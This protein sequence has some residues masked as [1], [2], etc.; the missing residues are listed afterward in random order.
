[1]RAPV[2]WIILR[3]A[4]AA[5]ALPA[6][7]Q[8]PKLDF[9]FP[10]GGRAGSRFGLTVS[11]G[12]KEG[13]RLQASHPG[14][15]F[16]RPNAKEWEVSIAADTPAGLHWVFAS[17][18]QGA[19]TAK[20]F[21]VDLWNELSEVEPNDSVAQAQA[22]PKTAGL[23][24]GGLQRAGDVDHFA[25]ELAAGQELALSLDAYGLG[26]AVDALL[27]VI[28][29][30]GQRQHTASDSRNLDPA[31]RFKAKASGRHVIEV[32][33]FPHPPAADVRFTG[34]SSLVYRLK[35]AAG[36]AVWAA[37]PAAVALDGKTQVRWLGLGQD[38]KP[39]SLKASQILGHGR[40][41]RLIAADGLWPVEVLSS[42]KT[43]QM[44]REPNDDPAKAQ[45]MELGVMGALLDR[46]G[47]VDVFAL[48]LKKGDNLRASVFGKRLGLAADFSLSVEGPDGKALGSA[49]D[50]G[51]QNSD[52]VLQFTATADGVHR[53]RV[54]EVM[55]R[56]PVL[57]NAYALEVIKPEA[58]VEL[59]LASAAPVMLEP[60]KS[61]TLKM[62][63]KRPAGIKGGLKLRVAGLPRGVAAPEVSIPEKDGDF[64]LVLQAA[65]NAPAGGG[66][67]VLEAWS[68]EAPITAV[69]AKFLFR[70]DNQR[71]LSAVDEIDLV[72]VGVLPPAK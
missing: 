1:M 41:R 26:S 67:V 25:L 2:A 38:S 68:L 46:A 63:A 36:K 16:W 47:D 65:A 8:V 29:P 7:S 31:T 33:G 37:H 32:A 23:I 15:S 6:W 17:N 52:P 22:L 40:L 42:A 57:G 3:L 20:L 48:S 64:S 70:A 13:D 66:P 58:E 62:T 24:N 56:L 54:N 71:G 27:H 14:I 4:F 5:A 10:A 49:D 18:A 44:E 72:W 30:D 55:R 9:L 59:T 28:G 19:S 50:L 45:T 51:E 53:I 11:G 34:G 43:V 61:Q 21:A 12:L 35:V 60:G 69:P 39:Q